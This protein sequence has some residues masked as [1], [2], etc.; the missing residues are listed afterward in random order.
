[1]I[2]GNAAP[3]RSRRSPEHELPTT[4]VVVDHDCDA[5]DRSG[6]RRDGAPLFSNGPARNGRS[7]TATP[8]F[9]ARLGAEQIEQQEAAR[10]VARSE[11]VHGVVVGRIV[12]VA[13]SAS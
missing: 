1:L 9:E 3:N 4:R 8:T 2:A 7:S 13:L 11:I 5:T 6:D 10:K 12:G